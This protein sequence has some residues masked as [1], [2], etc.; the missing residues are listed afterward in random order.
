MTK[1]TQPKFRCREFHGYLS[2]ALEITLEDGNEDQVID[3]DPIF[4]YLRLAHGVVS[5]YIRQLEEYE[6]EN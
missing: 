6:D 5:V 1:K 4:E 2:K 3:T